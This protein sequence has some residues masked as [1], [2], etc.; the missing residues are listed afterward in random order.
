[1]KRYTDAKTYERLR[2]SVVTIGT[3]DGVH[4]GHKKIIERLLES[5]NRDGLESIILTFFPHPRMVL[6]Q[7]SGIKLINTIEE[8]IQILEKTGLD[9]LVIHPFTQE[10]SR[11]TAGEYVQQMLIDCLDIRHVII[12]Y[13]HRFGRNRNS[14]ITDLASYGIQNDFT[15]EEI[16]KQ[17]IDDVAISSTKIREALLQGDVAKANTYLGYQFML[18]GKVIKGKELGRKLNYPTANL[19]IAEDYKLV[20]KNGVYIV[21][22]HIDGKTYFGMMNIG[23][24]PTVNGTTQ[25]IETHFFD[26]DFNLYDK[27]IQIQML[28]RIRDE[29]KFESI[30]ELQDAMQQDED[31]SREYIDSLV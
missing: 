27:K 31:F 23:T 22:S 30:A 19:H 18:T 21:K 25:S 7:D 6:Q 5:A 24:N 3:F 20:P 12:G 29:K 1:M 17:D 28:K 9:S 26:A 8:R 13:D 16:S 2:P 10:F 15:V 14:N 11:L 4:I